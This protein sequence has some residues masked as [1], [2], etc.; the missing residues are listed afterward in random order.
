MAWRIFELPARM[1]HLSLPRGDPL[2]L[3]LLSQ[4]S[5]PWGRASSRFYLSGSALGTGPGT[6]WAA[7]DAR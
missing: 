7:E 2:L 6:E 3:G 5:R 1:Q 4:S